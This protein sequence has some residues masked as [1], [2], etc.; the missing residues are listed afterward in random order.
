[1]VHHNAEQHANNR[2]ECDHCRLKARLRSMRGL[3]TGKGARVGSRGHMFIQNLRRGQYELGT[4]S[5][6]MRK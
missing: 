3:K 5:A 4:E 1:M 2:F 6:A